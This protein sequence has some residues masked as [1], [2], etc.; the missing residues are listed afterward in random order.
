M[1]RVLLLTFMAILFEFAMVAQT[2]SI[3]G[4]VS[5]SSGAVVPGAKVTVK[6]AAT[7]F[8]RST[9]STGTGTWSMP[10]VPPGSYTLTV[11]AKGFSTAKFE[12]VTLTV[13]QSLQLNATL[14]P[15][16]VSEV[17]EVSAAAAPIIE[18][19]NAQISN[20]I[21]SKKIQQLPLVTRNPYDL[22]LLSPGTIQ[23]NSALG[24]FSVNGSRERNNNFLLDGVDNNDASVP[25]IPGGATNLNPDSTEEFRVITNNFLA[26]YGRNTGAIIEVVTK[27]GTNT[28]KGNAY[29][30]GRYNAMA[31]RDWFNPKG[32]TQHPFVR[33]M[34]GGSI[35]GP[36]IKDRTF[37]FF[38]NEWQR[39]RT[40]LT[41][42]STL[43]TAEFKSGL[44]TWRGS[45]VDLRTPTSASNAQRVPLDPTMQKVFAL[46]PNPNGEK[47]DDIRGIYRF[48]STSRTDSANLAFRVDHRFN[49]RHSLNLRYSY[50]GARDPNGSFD[51]LFP[52]FATIGAESQGHGIAANFTSALTPSVVNQFRAGVNRSDVPFYCSGTGALDSLRQTDAFGAATDYLI[53][54]IPGIGCGSLGSSLGQTRRAGTWSFADSLSFVRG[55]HSMKV[56]GEYRFV[57]ENGYN[58]F[59]SRQQLDFDYYTT[60][61]RAVVHINPAQTCRPNTGA[62]CGSTLLQNM[63][64]SLLGLVGS[65]AQSQYFDAKGV[66]TAND[67]RRLRQKEFAVF[68]QDSW[69]IRPN[70]TMTLGARYQLFGVPYEVNNGLSNLFND[71]AGAGPIQFT[72]VGRAT[73]ARLYDPDRNNIEP[74]FGFSW[75]PFRKGKTSVRGGYGIFHDRVFGNLF[76]NVR[77]NPPF[78]QDFTRTIRA[79]TTLPAIGLPPVQTPSLKVPEDSYL[80]PTLFARD[81]RNPI[82]QN[83]NMGV[84]HELTHGLSLDLAYVGSKA[85]RLFRV[86]DG[87]PPQPAIIRRLLATGT[88]PE[89]LQFDGLTFHNP[90]VSY[91]TAIF[92]SLIKTIGN[93]TYHSLQ[94]R[95]S[96]RF[97]DRFEIDAAY[98]WAHSIDDASDPLEAT[99][100]NRSFPRNSLDLHQER[101]NSGFDVRQRL[102]LTYSLDLPFGKGQKHLTR[103]PGAWVLGNWQLSGFST[104]QTGLPFDIFGEVDNQH[105]S[106][107][108]RVDLVG[109]PLIPAGTPRNQTGPLM[110]A[111]RNAPLGLT[112]IPTLGRNVFYGPG[113]LNTDLSLVKEMTFGE[114]FRTQL[115][116][117][118]Y[119]VFNR[120]QFGQ[121]GQSLANPGTFGLSTDT[122]ARP[123]GTTS[124]RQLQLALKINF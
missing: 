40:T 108:S 71:A 86:V 85:N 16:A 10:A 72:I 77:G 104:F 41:Q 79:G 52:G 93:S 48:P 11:E 59:G 21:T 29:W 8:S 65:Q 103:G 63:S 17:V 38:N 112:R 18:L 5:D 50:N 68:F 24:G 75:D 122:V 87:N 69:K 22:V 116:V 13:A 110:S 118:A 89:E 28:L 92:P 99:A 120:P 67:N 30:F 4:T 102:V 19:E 26:E 81:V 44:F 1:K 39:F 111:F 27:G 62:N 61:N 37:F 66:R 7:A 51:E 42:Q 57:F 98:T 6:N 2:G 83:W 123:D 121:P 47:V 34:F 3:A 97:G 117:E 9:E 43:P 107:A 55:S 35:G 60:L 32:E 74:R 20:I 49:D 91:N 53:G 100:G 25:G 113:Q 84:Q 36:V 58:G 105:T 115:R 109:T 95:A 12:A 90:P 23:S 124:N 96:Q 70:F 31:A 78:Q 15:G 82:S 80:F 45:T 33:N 106:V 119:N 56:G 101:G 94:A 46:L 54:G 76:G 88:D 114:R 73:G 64:A 14:S